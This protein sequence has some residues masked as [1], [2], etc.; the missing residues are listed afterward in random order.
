MSCN[1]PREEDCPEDDCDVCDYNLD[2]T[3]GKEVSR[4]DNMVNFQ[5]R[6]CELC[7]YAKTL[8]DIEVF[9]VKHMYGVEKTECCDEFE[10]S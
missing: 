8:V 1:K 5:R 3:G 2:R 9:C 6:D 10:A 4:F 7:K